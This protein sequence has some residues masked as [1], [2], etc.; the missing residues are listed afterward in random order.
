MEREGLLAH[1]RDAIQ[2]LLLL[3]LGI[4]PRLSLH[5]PARLLKLMMKLL[6]AALTTYSCRPR[7]MMV[8]GAVDVLW[9]QG[10]GAHHLTGTKL[11]RSHREVRVLIHTENE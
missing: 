2:D 9:G 11:M 7:S 4:V 5:I 3:A 10:S 1:C 8:E 6:I